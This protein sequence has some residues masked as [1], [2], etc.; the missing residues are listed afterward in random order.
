MTGSGRVVG[1]RVDQAAQVRE[2]ARLVD[3]GLLSL[4]QYEVQRRRV[5]DG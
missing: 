3:R 5:L 4:D 2:L 1:A